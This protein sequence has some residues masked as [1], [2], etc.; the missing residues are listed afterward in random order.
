MARA[1]GK[2]TKF[3]SESPSSFAR[4]MREACPEPF[5]ETVRKIGVTCERIVREAY[6]KTL[7]IST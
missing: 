1:S 5:A 7:R 2:T 6:R 4:I 3:P